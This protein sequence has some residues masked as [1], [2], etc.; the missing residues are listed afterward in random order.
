MSPFGRSGSGGESA[1]VG[2]AAR[3]AADKLVAGANA[4]L[5]HGGPH[6]F[7]TW[8]IADLDLALMLNRLVRNGDTVPAQL[9]DYATRQ[10]QR[11]SVQEW[12]THDRPPR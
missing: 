1:V 10:W 12:V 2:A 11:P 9:A 6:L 5:A 7:D 3:A 8:S 4:L